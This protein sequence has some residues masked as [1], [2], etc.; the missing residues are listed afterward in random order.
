MEKYLI[1]NLKLAYQSGKGRK[2]VPVLFPIDTLEPITKL[3][4]ERSNSNVSSENNYL[5]PNTGQSTDHASGYHCLRSVV[6]RC[7]GL[8]QPRLL[9]ADKFR[10]RVSTIFSRLDIPEEQRSHFYR[11]MGHSE[12]VNKNVYQCP[13]AVTEITQVGN[14]LL[15]SIDVAQGQTM[16][17]EDEDGTGTPQCEEMEINDTPQSPTVEDQN[18]Q[19]ENKNSSAKKG[20][21]RQYT[22]WSDHESEIINSYFKEYITDISNKGCLPSKKEVLEF[23][24]KYKVLDGYENKATLVRTKV[25]NEKNFHSNLQKKVEPS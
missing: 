2:L 21:Q 12:S 10:H 18:V 24:S 6:D 11:H 22:K 1:N 23:L 17:H 9:I 14:F 19:L 16:A 8:K 7:P 13:L 15:N 5:F 25:F 3:L 20:T 4:L